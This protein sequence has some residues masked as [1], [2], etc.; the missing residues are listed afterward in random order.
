VALIALGAM[1]LFAAWFDTFPG[2]SAALTSFQDLRSPWLDDTAVVITTFAAPYIAFISAGVLA[3]MLWAA[4]RRHD[5]VL[6]LAF[7]AQG[8]GFVLRRLVDR[9]RPDFSLFSPPPESAGFPS[10][11][12]LHALILCGLLMYIVTD[13]VEPRWLRLGI[14]GF[15]VLTTLAVGA[16]RVYLGVHWPSGVVGGFLL[17]AITL[18]IVFWLRKKLLS[19]QI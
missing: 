8:V 14:H 7:G 12:S 16:S 5:M 6:F 2:D 13:V 10:G 11:H 3:L 9:P 1:S 17:G 15:L 18:V 19:R 4:R